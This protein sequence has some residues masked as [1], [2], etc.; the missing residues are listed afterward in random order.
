MISPTP[1][2]TWLGLGSGLGLGLGS[3]SG[4]GSGQWSGS[5]LGLGFRVSCAAAYARCVTNP[6]STMYSETAT[7]PREKKREVSPRGSA[8]K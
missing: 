4:L 1:E 5:G 7:W 6:E 2:R 3:G 8:A